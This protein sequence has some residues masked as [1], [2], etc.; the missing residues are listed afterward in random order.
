MT[1]K[2]VARVTALA[3]LLLAAGWATGQEENGMGEAVAAGV[4]V[5]KGLAEMSVEAVK[6][7]QAAVDGGDLAAAQDA[8]IASRPYYERIEV[9]AN[10]FP[11][12]DSDIDARPYS[13]PHGEGIEGVDDLEEPGAFFKG[14]HRIEGLLFR[15]ENISAA[16]RWMPILL[17]SSEQLVKDLCKPEEFNPVRSFE[18]MI[19]LST[20][21]GAKKMSSEEE[22]FS[23]MSILIYYNNFLGIESQYLPFADMAAEAD[24]D[25]A[26]AVSDAIDAAK[27]SVEPFMTKNDDGTVTYAK[28][29]EVDIPARAGIQT[30]AY[31]LAEALRA[32]KEALGVDDDSGEEEEGECTATDE[33]TMESPEI[34]AG[35]DYFRALMPFQIDL[36]KEL[37]EA[38]DSGDLDAVKTAYTRSRPIYEQVEVLAASFPDIDSDLDARP[39]SFEF[40]EFDEAFKGFHKLERF[41]FR[42]EK[43]GRKTKDAAAELE[44]ITAQLNDA[45]TDMSDPTRFTGLTTFEGIIGLSTEVPSR[46][47][48]SEEEVFSDLSYLIYYNNWKGIYSQISP[49]LGSVSEDLAQSVR[50]AVLAAEACLPIEVPGDILDVSADSVN[51]DFVNNLIDAD[52]GSYATADLE[53][54]ECITQTSYALRNLAVQVADDIDLLPECSDFHRNNVFNYRH[55][56]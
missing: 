49:F 30:A 3:V 6:E 8:Y 9:L 5:L 44:D 42:D 7:L 23:D 54:R 53:I 32:V 16:A 27:K 35:L 48:S 56:S 31:D 11:D 26:Q 19:G 36:V 40:G 51:Q 4:E 55:H 28:Y 39:Y 10:S 37:S 34:S 18:G 29:S 46:K 21:V 12:T 24:P 52:Y 13:F 15:N 43:L 17:A 20:E 33:F 1:T 50:D 47:I 2:C 38:I 22:T 14:F 25:A 41:I 45:L